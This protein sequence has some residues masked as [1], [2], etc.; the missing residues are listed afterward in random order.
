ME[1]SKWQELLPVMR[2]KHFS[3]RTQTSTSSTSLQNIYMRMCS[4]ER[5]KSRL[6]KVTEQTDTVVRMCIKE[7]AIVFRPIFFGRVTSNDRQK[8]NEISAQLEMLQTILYLL[9]EEFI[10]SKLP[11]YLEVIIEDSTE[12]DEAAEA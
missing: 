5:P 7:L 10:R 4:D 2:S 6:C 9:G 11:G 12:D 1:I 8:Q 3:L